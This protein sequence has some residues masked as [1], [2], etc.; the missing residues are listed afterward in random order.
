MVMNDFSQFFF[1]M[2]LFMHLKAVIITLFWVSFQSL[3]KPS[4]KEKL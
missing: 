4:K 1:Q 3:W 2:F